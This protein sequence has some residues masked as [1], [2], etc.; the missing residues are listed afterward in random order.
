MSD[1]T[2]STTARSRIRSVHATDGMHILLVQ[3]FQQIKDMVQQYDY[4]KSLNIVALKHM[5]YNN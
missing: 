3:S 2:K 4:I 5:I 1:T